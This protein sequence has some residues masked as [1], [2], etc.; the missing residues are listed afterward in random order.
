MTTANLKKNIQEAVD[1]INDTKLLNAVYPI[2]ERE[3]DKD[4]DY[5]LTPSQIKELNLRLNDHRSG[6]N[7]SYLWD[8]VKNNLPTP[9]K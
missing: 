3:M 4:E 9:K 6:K 2:L 5:E 7:K 8:N 1:K